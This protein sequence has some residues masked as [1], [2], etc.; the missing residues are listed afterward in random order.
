MF[1]NKRDV[2]AQKNS[3]DSP[4]RI[5]LLTRVAVPYCI[6]KPARNCSVMFS[7]AG[8][9]TFL[10]F[11][12]LRSASVRQNDITEGVVVRLTIP[13]I[14][15]PEYTDSQTIIK[16]GK[17]EARTP[18][19]TEI[20]PGEVVIVEGVME[21]LPDCFAS[22]G[23]S[24]ALMRL[25]CR[26]VRGEID[27]I[28]D[29]KPSVVDRF[30][31]RLSYVRKWAVG[32]IRETLPEPMASLAAGILLGI[33]AQMPKDFYQALINTGTLHVIAASGFNVMIVAEV[34]MGISKRVWRRGVAIGMGVLGIWLYVLLSGGSAS[35]VR[36]GIMGSLTLISYYWG[37]PTEARRL[38]WVTA[39]VMLLVDPRMLTDVGFQ[40]SVAATAGLLYIGDWMKH[41]AIELFNSSEPRLWIQEILTEYLYPTL[42]ASVATMPVILW[43]FG[44]ISLISP[45]V[46]MVILPVVPLI[47]G[48][49][50]AVLVGGQTVAWFA[51]VPLVYMV[52]VIR[53][54]GG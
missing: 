42:A 31:I 25:K 26:K 23:I 16:R 54:F 15:F 48:L 36:A 49:T 21:G 45:L 30:L 1:G 53:I 28:T 47:M 43:H 37:R 32:R 10:L 5:A 29:G 27:E 40:L 2:P 19:Y 18:G 17:W 4:A 46:N 52:G 44:R 3:V 12:V 38:L 33:K 9:V 7:L 8:I 35:V 39:G 51:Y 11:F 50:A 20:T 24:Q 22:G 34:L 13:T 14:D 41:K 6:G